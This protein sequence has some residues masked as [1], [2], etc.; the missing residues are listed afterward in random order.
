MNIRI[1]IYTDG[2]CLKNPGPGGWAYYMEY[3]GSKKSGSGSETHTT[4]NKMELT[5]VIKALESLKK[6]CSVTVHTDSEYVYNAFCKGWLKKWE[7]TGYINSTGNPVKNRELWEKLSELAKKHD[8]QWV[9]VKAHSDDPLNILVD[10]LAG[11]AARGMVPEDAPGYI[12]EFSL[13]SRLFTLRTCRKDDIPQV[14]KINERTLNS[15]GLAEKQGLQE[16]DYDGFFKKNS[17]ARVL[18][19]NNCIVGFY[20]VSYNNSFFSKYFNYQGLDKAVYLI[21]IAVDSRFQGLGLGR[22]MLRDIYDLAGSLGRKKILLD[23]AS[24]NDKALN[25]YL[26]EGFTEIDKQI[27]MIREL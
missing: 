12:K 25:W 26:E 27:Y 6:H 20:W 8:I 10:S 19:H 14:K 17:T 5:A 16:S 13:G 22:T 23:V 24:S 15:K 1:I 2:S 3:M 7:K 18:E 21:A 9:K 4:N 11:E